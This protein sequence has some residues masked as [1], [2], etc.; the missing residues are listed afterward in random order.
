[1]LD[2]ASHPGDD[3]EGGAEE[4]EDPDE[5]HPGHQEM[6]GPRHHQ[7]LDQ[8]TGPFDEDQEDK[9]GPQEYPLQPAQRH[10]VVN[11]LQRGHPAGR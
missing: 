2:A 8:P 4:E 3:L 10:R 1:M 6:P 11:P 5:Q 7:R 9:G